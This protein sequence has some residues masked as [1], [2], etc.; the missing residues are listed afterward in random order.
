M[1]ANTPTFTTSGPAGGGTSSTAGSGVGTTQWANLDATQIGNEPFDSF[2]GS[3]PTEL[4]NAWQV[5]TSA[6]SIPSGASQQIPTALV[7]E[8]ISQPIQMMQLYYKFEHGEP[9]SEHDVETASRLGGSTAHAAQLMYADQRDPKN[10]T[11]AEAASAGKFQPAGMNERPSAKAEYE[12]ADPLTVAAAAKGDK[13]A[14]AKLAADAR[15]AP[16][17]LTSTPS[18]VVGRHGASRGKVKVDKKTAAALAQ[19]NAEIIKKVSGLLGF[20]WDPADANQKIGS[21]VAAKLQNSG[22]A[23]TSSMTAAQ[24]LNVVNSPKTQPAV[25]IPQGMTAGQY[26]QNLAQLSPQQLQGLQQQMFAQGLFD[27][28]YTTGGKAY[29]PGVLDSATIL[30][31]RNALHVASD[32]NVSLQT[33]IGSNLPMGTSAYGSDF[34]SSSSLP[35]SG[36]ATYVPQASSAQ[37]FKPLQAAFENELGRGPTQ[38]EVGKFTQ[39]YD[40]TQQDAAKW[41]ID[42][43]QSPQTATDLQTGIP[44]IDTTPTVTNAAST[45]AM[46]SNPVEYQATG[47]ANAFSMLMKL[48][49]RSGVGALDTPGAVRTH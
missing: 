40:T 13:A 9:L 25:T 6:L 32:N 12:N 5:P 20:N 26:I 45:D 7:R 44:Y 48:V 39:Q 46:M 4:S 19:A 38:G 30:A 18:E 17:E 24:M 47:I 3:N 21:S 14:K 11:P 29:T 36:S 31:F 35:G 10:V 8:S 41:A 42:H 15:N 37:T 23:V 49:D 2:W 16:R 28:S 34:G 43:G 33:V 22:Y 27:T 1:A